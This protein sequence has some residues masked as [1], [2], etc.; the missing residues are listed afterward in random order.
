MLKAARRSLLPLIIVPERDDIKPEVMPEPQADDIYHV[1]TCVS[2]PPDHPFC[3]L[4]HMPPTR[5]KTPMYSGREGSGETPVSRPKVWKCSTARRRPINSAQHGPRMNCHR[6]NKVKKQTPSPH[7]LPLYMPYAIPSAIIQTSSK[8]EDLPL[9][10]SKPK[11]KVPETDASKIMMGMG[12]P[13]FTAWPGKSYPNGLMMPY[14]NSFSPGRGKLP[15]FPYGSHALDVHNNGPYFKH[16]Q[17]QG[18]LF[19]WM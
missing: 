6:S 8:T 10:L 16:Q 1:M 3:N 17:S 7:K 12:I 5:T 2:L 4:V 14:R 9:D 13:P 15:C 11:C 18:K 19:E